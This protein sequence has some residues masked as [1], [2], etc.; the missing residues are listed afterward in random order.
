M[1]ND[2]K[3]VIVID[4]EATCW[5]TDAETALNTSEII[6][7]GVC[8]L[9]VNSGEI[10]KQRGIIVNPIASKVSPFCT[11]LTGITQEMVD[12]GVSFEQALKIL[13]EEYRVDQKVLAA[14]GNYDQN[15]LMKECERHCL[16]P[17]FGPTY[18]NISALATMKLKTRRLSLS[19]ACELYELKFE[20]RLHRGVD[21]A[22]MAAKVLWE[23]IK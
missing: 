18:M 10:R 1:S 12:C 11:E 6:E 14:W 16:K 21:D 13:R 4:L 5:E 19:R 3:E 2:Y 23:I 9:D 7:V 20:G 17:P 22:V 15:M 8:I